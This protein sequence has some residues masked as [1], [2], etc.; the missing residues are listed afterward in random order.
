MYHCVLSLCID[1]KCLN[2]KEKKDILYRLGI[3][4][5]LALAAMACRRRMQSK[6]APVHTCIPTADHRVAVISISIALFKYR[7]TVGI[8]YATSDYIAS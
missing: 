6:K 2:V 5:L 3:R 8:L 1:D 4:H 7:K